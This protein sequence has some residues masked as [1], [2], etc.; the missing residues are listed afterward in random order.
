M[1]PKCTTNCNCLPGIFA[2][3]EY[4]IPITCNLH[5]YYRDPARFP[6]LVARILGDVGV[7]GKGGA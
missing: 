1:V 2:A 3:V 4:E 5:H 7:S 6:L